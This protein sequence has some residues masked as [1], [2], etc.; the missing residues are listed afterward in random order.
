MPIEKRTDDD[1]IRVALAAVLRRHDVRSTEY[2][3]VRIVAAFGDGCRDQ[4]GALL[5][6]LAEAAWAGIGRASVARPRSL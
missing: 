2:G 3:E 1:P 4:V 5:D 6:E